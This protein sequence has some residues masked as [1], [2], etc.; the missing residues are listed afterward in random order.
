LESNKRAQI[1]IDGE[2][3]LLTLIVILHA[4]KNAFVIYG[5]PNEGIVLIKVTEKRK[6]EVRSILKDMKTFRKAK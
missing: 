4:P 1:V 2:E 6:E 3:D 5:Q